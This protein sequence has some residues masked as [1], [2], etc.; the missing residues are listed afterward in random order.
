MVTSVLEDFNIYQVS[1]FSYVYIFVDID[2]FLEDYFLEEDI[3]AGAVFR[4]EKDAIR[5]FCLIYFDYDLYDDDFLNMIL[6]EFGLEDIQVNTVVYSRSVSSSFSKL[7]N[8]FKGRKYNRIF[9]KNCINFVKF[10]ILYKFQVLVKTNF[11]SHYP[12][13]MKLLSYYPYFLV[14]FFFLFFSNIQGLILF[15]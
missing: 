14:I 5:D 6:D 8:F 9:F 11:G 2:K 12:F 15:D 1:F 10:S 4:N 7:F 13:F 3:L